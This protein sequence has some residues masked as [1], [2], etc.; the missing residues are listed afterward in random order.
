MNTFKQLTIYDWD[1]TIQKFQCN[2]SIG[3]F[4]KTLFTP[5]DKEK[6]IS[7][8]DDEHSCICTSRSKLYT[9]LIRIKCFMVCPSSI[10]FNGLKV[11]TIN[12]FVFYNKDVR[13][14]TLDDDKTKSIKIMAD[15][16]INHVEDLFK[17]G[18]H[19]EYDYIKYYDDDCP[20]GFYEQDNAFYKNAAKTLNEFKEKNGIK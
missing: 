6:I 9:F 10:W 19:S 8:I 20:E 14:E 17:Y 1:G 11:I 12:P 13:P 18:K 15:I 2:S 4:L 16:K 3:M 7:I 5:V